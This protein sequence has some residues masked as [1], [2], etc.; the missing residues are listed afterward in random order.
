MNPESTIKY[1]LE[2]NRCD[3]RAIVSD[4]GEL[5]EGDECPVCGDSTS[6]M[7][8]IEQITQ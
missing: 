4:D 5:R 3:Y 8:F 6:E 2:C 1:K 7:V